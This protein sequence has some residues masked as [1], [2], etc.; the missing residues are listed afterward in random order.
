MRKDMIEPTIEHTTFSKLEFPK[1]VYKYR[2][3]KNPF[4]RTILSKR[5]VYFAAPETFED[6]FDCQN[7]ERYDLL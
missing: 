6:E 3:A 1:T 4:H 7:P 5:I 2:T